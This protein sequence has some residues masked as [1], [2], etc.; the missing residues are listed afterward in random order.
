MGFNSAFKGLKSF[1]EES[2][3]FLLLTTKNIPKANKHFHGRLLYSRAYLV[4]FTQF[5]SMQQYHYFT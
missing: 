2:Q 1:T 5:I 3:A 4:Y